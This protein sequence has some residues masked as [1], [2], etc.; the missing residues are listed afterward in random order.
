MPR[1]CPIKTLVSNPENVP[2]KQLFELN[3]YSPINFLVWKMT[4]KHD[5]EIELEIEDTLIARIKKTA[6]GPLVLPIRVTQKVD[7]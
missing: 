7:D 1:K 2:Y 4:T 6:H 5:E 3:N